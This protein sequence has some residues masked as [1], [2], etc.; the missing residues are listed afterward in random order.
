MDES[1][2]D[3]CRVCYVVLDSENWYPSSQKKRDHICKRCNAERNRVWRK[4]NP[5][6]EQAKWTRAN[7]K[8]G[9]LSFDE[10]KGCTQYLG[11]HVAERVLSLVFKDVK[12]MPMHNPGYD[13]ICNH[14]ML[15]DIKSSCK[16][17]SGRWTFDIDNNTKADHFLFLAFDDR[18]RLNPL[19]AWL[20]PGSKIN[21]LKNAS[22]SPSTLHKWD[23]YVLDI[24]KIST[25]CDTIRGT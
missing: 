20:I 18:E 9:H 5:E 22:V 8:Q 16:R 23:P 24:S 3:T 17:K 14:G 2:T 4:A 10:N 7:R 1:M 11:I 13:V 6:K 19:H 12:R 21:H 25:C 15:I